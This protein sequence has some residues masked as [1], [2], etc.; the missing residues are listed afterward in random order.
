MENKSSSSIHLRI[1]TFHLVGLPIWT[2]SSKDVWFFSW[3]NFAKCGWKLKASWT[4]LHWCH[5]GNLKKPFMK[6]DVASQRNSFG[7]LYFS[8]ELQIALV[9]LTFRYPVPILKNCAIFIGCNFESH[10]S[11]VEEP[12]EQGRVIFK[13]KRNH[14]QNN[15]HGRKDKNFENQGNY[16]MH[17]KWL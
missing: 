16:K 10:A 9:F 7:W 2:W 8:W 11:K 4:W 12:K 13:N 15:D 14:P 6:D 1:T 17:W 3:K 5:S